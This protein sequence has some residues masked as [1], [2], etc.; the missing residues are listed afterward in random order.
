MTDVSTIGN[1][2]QSRIDSLHGKN[3]KSKGAKG[4][5]SSDRN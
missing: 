5:L 3:S 1:I 2:G 4:L